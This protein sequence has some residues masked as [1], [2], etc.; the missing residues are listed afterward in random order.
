MFNDVHRYTGDNEH[1]CAT[2]R[3]LAMDIPF[4]SDVPCMMYWE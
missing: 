2:L 1:V 3:A 4:T